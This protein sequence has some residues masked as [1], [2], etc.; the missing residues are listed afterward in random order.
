MYETNCQI[1][2]DLD[3]IDVRSELRFVLVYSTAGPL[4]RGGV[5][6]DSL[7]LCFVIR[8]PGKA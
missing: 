7:E 3:A 2:Y 1:I 6:P 5:S 8:V 4:V